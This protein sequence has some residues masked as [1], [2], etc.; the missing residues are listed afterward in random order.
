MTKWGVPARES[1]S[2][3]MR[4]VSIVNTCVTVTDSLLLVSI[5]SCGRLPVQALPAL[6]NKPTALPA[7]ALRTPTAAC[8]MPAGPPLS[9]SHLDGNLLSNATPVELHNKDPLRFK[10]LRARCSPGRQEPAWSC[11]VG[12]D[13]WH[14]GAIDLDLLWRTRPEAPKLHLMLPR[15]PLSRK[16]PHCSRDTK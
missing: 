7:A 4:S 12:C 16:T 15:R 3:G 9:V 11:L 1:G 13:A 10:H 14:H 5:H 8:P 6:H 2:G